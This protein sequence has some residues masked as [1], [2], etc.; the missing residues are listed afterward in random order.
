MCTNRPVATK[1][2]SHIAHMKSNSQVIAQNDRT[3]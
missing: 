2:A 3:E 1:H